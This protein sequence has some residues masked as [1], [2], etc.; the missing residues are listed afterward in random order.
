M[1][2][3]FV[4]SASLL[5]F[6]GGPSHHQIALTGY[7]KCCME[8]KR[9]QCFEKMSCPSGYSIKHSR[10]LSN[11]LAK[12]SECTVEREAHWSLTD[13][14]EMCNKNAQSSPTLE[15]ACSSLLPECTVNSSSRS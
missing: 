15:Q 12:H 9:K 10:L 14:P 11:V 4:L 1:N 2:S 8:K 7:S 3:A 6:G 13:L 5:T